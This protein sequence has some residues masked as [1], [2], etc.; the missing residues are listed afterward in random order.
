MFCRLG[1]TAGPF[2]VGG[3]FTLFVQSEVIFRE[4]I[5]HLITHQGS[6][7]GGVVEHPRPDPCAEGR[8][9]GRAKGGSYAEY[10]TSILD[11]W[12]SCDS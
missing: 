8:P 11:I 2:G 12:V 6:L 9:G 5:T 10:R 4:L 7:T 3:C 1:D